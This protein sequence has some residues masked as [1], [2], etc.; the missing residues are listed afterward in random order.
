MIKEALANVVRHAGA[1][2]V[3]VSLEVSATRIRAIVRDD[4]RGI[5]PDAGAGGGNGLRNIRSRAEEAGGSV[6]LE[7]LPG[8]GTAVTVELPI[9]GGS[10]DRGGGAGSP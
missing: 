4:G 8:G 9:T 3:G 2:S 10:A 7:S 5:G 6:I 1:R